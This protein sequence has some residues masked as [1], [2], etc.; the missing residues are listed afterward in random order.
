MTTQKNTGK[1]ILCGTETKGISK[2]DCHEILIIIPC[3]ATKKRTKNQENNQNG[4]L[5]NNLTKAVMKE[6]NNEKYKTY[7]RQEVIKSS[8]LYKVY[9]NQIPN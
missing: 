7:G 4:M 6:L 2:V 3:T 9:V 8:Q 1:K 5:E